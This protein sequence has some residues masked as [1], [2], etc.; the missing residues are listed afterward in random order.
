MRS[1]R[2]PD[3]GLSLVRLAAFERLQLEVMR[4]L[5]GRRKLPKTI[6]HAGYRFRIFSIAGGRLIVV[7]TYS[8]HLTIFGVRRTPVTCRPKGAP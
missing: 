4:R 7:V 5:D 3:D 8:G 2:P 6:T 1:G